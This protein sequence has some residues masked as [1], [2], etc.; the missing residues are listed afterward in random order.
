VEVNGLPLVVFGRL[1]DAMNPK[2]AD[3]QAIAT[4]LD[5]TTALCK[6]VIASHL[7]SISHDHG[8]KTC[9]LCAAVGRVLDATPQVSRAVG[10]NIEAVG[11]PIGSVCAPAHACAHKALDKDGVKR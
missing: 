7:D 2:Q 6:E 5:A 8:G 10:L 3:R 9:R 11:Q 1:E 4:L